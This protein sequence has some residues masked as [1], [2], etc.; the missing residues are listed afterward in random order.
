MSINYNTAKPLSGLICSYDPKN[1]KSY[2]GSGT[3]IT[4]LTGTMGNATLQGFS[5]TNGT[6]YNSSTGSAGITVP[7]TNFNKI[8]GSIELWAKPESYVDSNGFFVNR[9]D[10]TANATD[11]LWVGVYGAGSTLYFRLGDGSTCCNNDNA[12]GSWSSVHPTGVWGHYVFTWV[13][14]S[15]SK[16]YFNGV[17]K[18]STAITTIP[19]TNPSSTGSL[20]LGHTAG[21]SKW[22][23]YLSLFNVYNRDI[24]QDEVTQNFNSLRG[25]FGI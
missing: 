5:Y 23:G 4:D 13:Y 24:T 17:L 1:I 16:I 19:A 18:Q 12:I 8:C 20:G 14:G 15:T 21:N 10:S 7:L 22:L 2:S 11:W 6:W 3:T 9:S 25:R